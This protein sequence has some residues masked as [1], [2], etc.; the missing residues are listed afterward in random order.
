MLIF[1]ISMKKAPLIQ[2]VF[3]ILCFIYL[4]FNKVSAQ[5][6]SPFCNDCGSVN[7]KPL[8]NN[9]QTAKCPANKGNLE[10]RLVD[11]V[12]TSVCV[13]SNSV[14]PDADFCAPSTSS[15]SSSGAVISSSSSGSTITLNPNFAGTW[16]GKDLRANV[17]PNSLIGCTE[18]QNCSAKNLSCKQDEILLPTICTKCA[19]C[20]KASKTITL[21]LC[22]ND[23]QL[24]G[25]VNHP[26]ILKNGSIIS[27]TILTDN[28][29]L[30][31]L[32]DIN[33]ETSTLTLQLTGNKKLSGTF[34]SGI[35]FDGRKSNPKSNCL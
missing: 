31:N 11:G 7:S 1:T 28:I 33:G 22:I 15:S 13:T 35:S 30:L 6:D 26:G 20:T 23:G 18:I 9:S 3:L 25:T 34:S 32:K 29:I 16:K 17:N 5:T 8:C 4:G 10:C 24:K 27:Q 21:N 19:R 14:D 2:I 12:C